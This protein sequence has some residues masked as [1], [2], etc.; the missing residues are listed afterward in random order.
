[1][2]AGKPLLIGW[3]LGARD[4]WERLGR[5][6]DARPRRAWA[7][8]LVLVF[9]I[10]GA[11]AAYFPLNDYP[12]ATW[13]HADRGIDI[14]VMQEWAARAGPR[15]LLQFW[16]G[17]Y[18]GVKTYRPLSG[19]W[20]TAE[21]R[22]FGRDDHPWC[23]VSVGLHMIVVLLVTWAGSLWFG[24]R[25]R[26]RLAFGAAAALFFAGP[27]FADRYVQTWALGWWPC[28][29][30][31][32]SLI[33][34]LL[35]LGWTTLYARTGERR[36]AIGAAVAFVVAVGFKEMG[37]VAGLGACL[38]LLRRRSAWRLLAVLA[39]I[40][41][42]LFLLRA[43]MFRGLVGG[44]AQDYSRLL[45]FGASQLTTHLNGLQNALPLAG[46]IGLGVAL[47]LLLRRRAGPSLAAA[48]GAAVF[49]TPAFAIFG[50]PGQEPFTS[51]AR[52]LVELLVAAALLLGL[53]RS[54]RAWP[55]GE[56][57]AIAFGCL[58]MGQTFNHALAWHRYWDTGFKGFVLAYALTGLAA[59]AGE[60]P[61]LLPLRAALAPA[62][63]G[64]PR[65]C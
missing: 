21:W 8:T 38:L 51:M 58:L 37:Y 18:Y 3:L 42:T 39:C 11:E 13:H 62:A 50:L 25:L 29:P 49:A 65:R 6:A 60:S 63:Q 14:E 53:A 27:F 20:I 54:F 40:G 33:F 10:T 48:V 30:D 55:T 56:V 7:L 64:D 23:A 32:L 9:L 24:E 22:L 12:G 57:T 26:D 34:G 15:D 1:M 44:A 45:R 2:S 59:W 17:T 28:Q 43:W 47:F 19:M 36:W 61:R 31:L 16:I 46:L 4:G 52:V 41:V 5:L 35:L